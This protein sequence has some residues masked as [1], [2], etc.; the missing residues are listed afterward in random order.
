MSNIDQFCYDFYGLRKLNSFLPAAGAPE[1][2][3]PPTAAPGYAPRGVAGPGRRPRRWGSRTSPA[4]GE[5]DG[6]RMGKK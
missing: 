4:P 1:H 5:E 3:V 6:Q 2:R